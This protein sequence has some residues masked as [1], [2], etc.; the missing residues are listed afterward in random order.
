MSV[1]RVAGDWC[2]WTLHWQSPLDRE[3]AGRVSPRESGC[4]S[5]STLAKSPCPGHAL[6]H[7]SQAGLPEASEVT[8]SPAETYSNDIR[9]AGT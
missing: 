9:F 2:R 1:M 4:E 5:P 6:R 7:Q 8:P 3:A